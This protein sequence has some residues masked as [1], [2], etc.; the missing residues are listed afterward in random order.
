MKLDYFIYANGITT[1]TKLQ[2]VLQCKT[3]TEYEK[4]ELALYT[5]KLS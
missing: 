2:K 3:P 5:G 4:I 1:I